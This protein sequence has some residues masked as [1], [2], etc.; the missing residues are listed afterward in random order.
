LIIARANEK[1]FEP[2]RRYMVADSPTWAH[3]LLLEKGIVVKDAESL[4]FWSF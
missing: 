1:A 3:P 2:I 4:A